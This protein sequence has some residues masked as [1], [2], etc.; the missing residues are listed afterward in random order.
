MME[1]IPIQA[2][3]VHHG[4]H[5]AAIRKDR[6]GYECTAENM[7]KLCTDIKDA[8]FGKDASGVLV[9]KDVLGL[10]QLESGPGDESERQLTRFAD[11]L[12]D[13]I[14]EEV[15]PQSKGMMKRSVT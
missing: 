6:N 2:D 4:L 15:I 8:L 5:S 10:A 9:I 12:A 3:H 13:A 11:L 14:G 1:F 7:Q